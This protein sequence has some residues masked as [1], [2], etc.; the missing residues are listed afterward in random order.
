ML[1]NTWYA[2]EDGIPIR[3]FLGCTCDGKCLVTGV[4]NVLH[5][6][7]TATAQSI[8]NVLKFPAES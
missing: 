3:K 7:D 5:L 8:S 4:R 2:L 6:F 1:W